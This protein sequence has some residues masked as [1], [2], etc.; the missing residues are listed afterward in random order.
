MLNVT[1]AT[2]NSKLEN[3]ISEI[4]EGIENEVKEKNDKVKETRKK[5]KEAEEK[6]FNSKEKGKLI[7]KT[8]FL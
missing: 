1:I 7:G 3:C 8:V 5:L 4:R 2:S 6:W